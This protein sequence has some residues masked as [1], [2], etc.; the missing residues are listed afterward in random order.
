MQTTFAKSI[1]RF[2]TKSYYE[3]LRPSGHR[4]DLIL[5][6]DSCIAFSSLRKQ[7]RNDMSNILHT[8]MGVND[9]CT[10]QIMCVLVSVFM[11]VYIPMYVQWNF[12]GSNSFGTFKICSRQ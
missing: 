9:L 2:I 7:G 11:S 8:N 1:N 5:Q 3:V 4:L 10:F 6:I 12:S